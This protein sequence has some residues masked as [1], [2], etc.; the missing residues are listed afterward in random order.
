[1]EGRGGGLGPDAGGGRASAQVPVGGRG[2]AQ[3]GPVGVEAGVATGPPLVKEVPRLV[4]GH[5]DAPEPFPLLRAHLA[6]GLTVEE[7]VLLAGEAVDAVN[8][9]LVVHAG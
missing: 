3:R 7:D 9:L 4:Q 5:L 6:L 8:D 2:V 1:W